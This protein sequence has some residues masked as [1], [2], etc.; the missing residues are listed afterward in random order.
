MRSFNAPAIIS[1]REDINRLWFTPSPS[2]GKDVASKLLNILIPPSIEVG[3]NSLSRKYSNAY[4]LMN[5][6]YM[7]K[8]LVQDNEDCVYKREISG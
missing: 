2:N 6:V 4:T 5:E 1:S 7:L 3:I 8:K